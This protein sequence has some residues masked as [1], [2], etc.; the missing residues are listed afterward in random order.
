MSPWELKLVYFLPWCFDQSRLEQ[1][2]YHHCCSWK[3]VYSTNRLKIS[4]WKKIICGSRL[5]KTGWE[6][7]KSII[8]KHSSVNGKNKL[9]TLLLWQNISE[10]SLPITTWWPDWKSIEEHAKLFAIPSTVYGLIWVWFKWPYWSW[11][12]LCCKVDESNALSFTFPTGRRKRS[13]PWLI[14][15][16]VLLKGFSSHFKVLWTSLFEVDNPFLI[17]PALCCSSELTVL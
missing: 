3:H 12:V 11:S 1:A 14:S 7:R 8:Y 16:K 10:K 15:N 13:T 5:K 9:N 17:H 4:D 2:V 6:R